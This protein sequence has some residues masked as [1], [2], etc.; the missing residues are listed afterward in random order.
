MAAE[1]VDCENLNTYNI[2]MHLQV[3]G[4]HICLQTDAYT[5]KQQRSSF[6]IM[7][8]LVSTTTHIM[9]KHT[10]VSSFKPN[11]VHACTAMYVSL[12]QK[13]KFTNFE[14]VFIPSRSE[15]RAEFNWFLIP[16][17]MF[18]SHQALELTPTKAYQIPEER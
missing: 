18:Q 4:T 9:L 15:F 2:H 10:V 12:F 3:H 5:L 14:D 7:H 17:I 13:N 1:P 8:S 11:M 16:D 6:P